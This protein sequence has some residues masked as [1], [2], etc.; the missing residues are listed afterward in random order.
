MGLKDLFN[1]VKNKILPRENE[2]A[3]EPEHTIEDEIAMMESYTTP[4]GYIMEE[5]IKKEHEEQISPM[6]SI[7]IHLMVWGYGQEKL[8][9]NYF[10]R[11][12]EKLKNAVTRNMVIYNYLIDMLCKQ[13]K[14]FTMD[15]NGEVKDRVNKLSS[16]EII[17]VTE[18]PVLEYASKFDF[19]EFA[20]DICGDM[21]NKLVVFMHVI[22]FLAVN[23]GADESV[24]V[25]RNVLKE[26]QWLLDKQTYFNKL[27]MVKD[28][29]SFLK[30]C[31]DLSDNVCFKLMYNNL[32]IKERRQ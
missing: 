12:M 2:A 19:F 11:I 21:Q 5:K 17:S 15:E 20:D 16:K 13:A 8:P 14:P 31:C 29:K 30:D 9:S 22:N 25:N 26:N 32:Q 1:K 3:Q 18:N 27:G 28:E 23:S 4:R 6:L 24:P 10:C 7:V